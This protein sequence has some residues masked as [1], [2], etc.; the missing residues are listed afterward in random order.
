[1]NEATRLADE[2]ATKSM[3]RVTGELD[4]SKFGL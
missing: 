1:V 2:D 3:S 4:L